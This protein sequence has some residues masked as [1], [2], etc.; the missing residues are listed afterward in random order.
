MAFRLAM[1]RQQ[2]MALWGSVVDAWTVG[3]GAFELSAGGLTRD[4]LEQF[5]QRPR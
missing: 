5:M 3:L 4:E 1:L 2:V